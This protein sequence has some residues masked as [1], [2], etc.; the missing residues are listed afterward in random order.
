MAEKD[1]VVKTETPDKD[2]KNDEK[3]VAEH[4]QKKTSRKKVLFEK[5][6]KSEDDRD[7]NNSEDDDKSDENS[8]E[9]SDETDNN[10]SDRDDESFGRGLNKRDLYE[11]LRYLVISQRNISDLLTQI[12][13]EK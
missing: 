9:S 5:V 10:D 7:K 2:Q 6:E 1:Q 13:E 3:Q 4:K 11:L 8:S 12:F